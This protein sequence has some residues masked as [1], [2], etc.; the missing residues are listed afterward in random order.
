MLTARK[1]FIALVLFLSGPAVAADLEALKADC[2]SC[3]GPQGVST[4]AEIPIIAGQ[5]PEFLAKS[6]RGFQFWDRPCVKSTYKTG[7]NAGTKTDMC[8][9]AGKMSDDDITAVAAWYGEQTFV[10]A[11]QEFDA[12]IAAAGQA[13]HDEDCETCHAQGGTVAGRGP[14]LA[15][16]WMGYLRSTVK[17][18]PT[19]EHMCP[20]MMEK[21]I[22]GFNGEQIDQ[23]LNYYASQQE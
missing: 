2:D 13:L 11:K 20:P 5:T 21:K 14:R 19:G 1:G 7:S 3:H 4:H 17:F 8:K 9:I 16:Q 12:S 15:G 10:P 6:L 18:F 23:L 22:T